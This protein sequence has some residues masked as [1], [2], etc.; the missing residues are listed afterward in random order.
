MADKQE[1]EDQIALYSLGLLEGEELREIEDHIA[2]GCVICTGLLKDSDTVFTSLP[3]CLDDEPLSKDVEKKIYERLVDRKPLREKTSMFDFWKNLSPVWLN[4][5][6]AVSLALI[7]F[8][9]VSNIS[10][11]NRLHLQETNL[12]ELE[13]KLVKDKEMM[14]YVTNPNVNLV[15][16]G[17]KMPAME[18]SGKLLWDKDTDKG[19]F[20]VSN[21]P[22]PDKGKTYQLWAIEDGKP[23]SM[24][25][26]DV[27]KE[28]KSMM[29]IKLM[30]E[31]AASMQ[32]AVTLEP[33]GGMPQPTGEMYLYGSL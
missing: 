10:L 29:E 20:L 8:L 15:N 23:V 32:F 27:D 16:L 19:L 2:E 26:F 30:P 1:Y 18:A 13:A 21:I 11:R 6:T 3:F 31:P 12:S 4:L 5:G 7:I 22:V 33:A 17:S 28:G 25:V 9:V 14:A 24:G